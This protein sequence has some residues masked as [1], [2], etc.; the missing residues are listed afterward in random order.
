MGKSKSVFVSFSRRDEAAARSLIDE[1]RRHE[2]S[3]SDGV[4]DFKADAEWQQAVEKAIRSAD[5][6]IVILGGKAEPT[7]YQE[8]E[9]SVILES[10]WADSKKLLI[11]VLL[12]D[13]D[14]PSFLASFQPLHLPDATGGWTPVIQALQGQVVKPEP[15]FV[16][17]TAK[18]RERLKIV[19]EFAQRIKK[20]DNV[21]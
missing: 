1:L 12:G 15:I 20:D 7:K 11:P 18:L 4:G 21:W 5:A 2:F 19:E 13:A 6:V 9:W 17:D 3:V 10:H 14:L 16:K 8:L